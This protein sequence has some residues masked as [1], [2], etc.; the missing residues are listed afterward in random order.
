[1]ISFWDNRQYG[2]VISGINLTLNIRVCQLMTLTLFLLKSIIL[3]YH[4]L[5][6]FH[7][8][9]MLGDYIYEEI[10]SRRAC[11]WNGNCRGFI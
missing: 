9:K 10:K 4:K 11:T 2:I 1:M 8:R 5:F 6:K 7:H 3:L